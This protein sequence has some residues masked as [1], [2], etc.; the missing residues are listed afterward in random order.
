VVDSAGVATELESPAIEVLLGTATDRV[1]DDSIGSV[2]DLERRAVG[3]L[4]AAGK[5]TDENADESVED[6]GAGGGDGETATVEEL[7]RPA[8]DGKIKLLR[9]KKR[10]ENAD[11]RDGSAAVLETTEMAAGILEVELTP[12]D[13]DIT[14]AGKV[15]EVTAGMTDETMDKIGEDAVTL[16]T[17]KTLETVLGVPRLLDV[18]IDQCVETDCT[19]VS[20]ELDDGVPMKDVGIV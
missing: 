20:E 17:P 6:D 1:E 8:F 11:E 14:G 18:G 16:D 5:N 13:V 4:L 7:G 19:E 15:A 9:S 12:K 3:M 2:K 10:V